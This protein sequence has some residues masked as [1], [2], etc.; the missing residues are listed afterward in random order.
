M[1]ISSIL[2]GFVLLG[3]SIAFVFLPFRQKPRATLKALNADGDYDRKRESVLSALR[4]LDF[5]FKTGKVS[6]EDYTPVRTRLMA[7]AAQYFEQEKKEEEKLETL[8]QTRR[9][10]QQKVVNCDHCGESIEASQRFCSKCGSA[11][12]KDL[13]PSCG[14]KNRVGDLYCSSCGNRLEVKLEAVVQS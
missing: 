2:I 12:N 11:V 4:D 7:E 14:K 1:T 10:S 13:C 6:E 3:A 9:T 8:I 5:D